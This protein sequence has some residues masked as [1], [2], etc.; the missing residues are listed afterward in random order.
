M[1]DEAS[2][3]SLVSEAE[4]DVAPSVPQCFGIQLEAREYGAPVK[5]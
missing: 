5:F 1:K 2:R 3:S 4:D